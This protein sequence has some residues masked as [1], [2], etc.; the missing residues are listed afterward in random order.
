MQLL[1]SVDSEEEANELSLLFH[2]SGIPV[3]VEPD[4][5]RINPAERNSY[6]GYRVHIWLDEQMDDAKRL[7]RDPAYEVVS[8]V[9]VEAFYASMERQDAAKEASWY[10]A[11]ERW[12]NWF[13]G[14]AAVGLV[15]W[16]AI[17]VLPL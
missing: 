14:A 10:K 12:L 9:D 5:T 17:K 11:E 15:A 2:G 13:F 7:L 16:I 1:T 3:F 6:F 8:A 4:H